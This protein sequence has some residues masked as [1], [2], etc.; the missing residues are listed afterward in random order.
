ME[1][2]EE[3]ESQFKGNPLAEAMGASYRST[4]EFYREYV[5][6]DYNHEMVSRISKSTALAMVK[7]SPYF[8]DLKRGSQIFMAGAEADFSGFLSG[9]MN[10]GA[11]RI[12]PSEQKMGAMIEN[13]D[14]VYF[15]DDEDWHNMPFYRLEENQVWV[16]N[17]D[18]RYYITRPRKSE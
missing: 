5:T 15:D 12:T 8:K 16:Y 17:H 9:I 18:G 2:S 14:E 3:F 4:K 1:N 6:E 10:K 7:S 13:R 11:I